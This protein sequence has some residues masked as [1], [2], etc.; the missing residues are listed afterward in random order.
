MAEATSMAGLLGD[1]KL[2][3]DA[4][5]FIN[6]FLD[7]S[8]QGLEGELRVIMADV[9]LEMFCAGAQWADNAAGRA[10]VPKIL[11]SIHH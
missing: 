4:A 3:E 6:N 10:D 5:E 2:V 7:N 8:F 1:E 9:A 11:T